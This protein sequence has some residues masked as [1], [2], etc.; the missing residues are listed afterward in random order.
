MSNHAYGDTIPI[1][2]TLQNRLSDGTFTPYVGTF[3]LLVL[4]PGATQYN[5][6]SLTTNASGVAYY[7]LTPTETGYAS[8]EWKA[9]VHINDIDAGASF[10]HAFRVGPNILSTNTAAT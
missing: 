10:N 6:H 8:N 9:M 7:V 2:I 4:P 3:D 5:T 1:K